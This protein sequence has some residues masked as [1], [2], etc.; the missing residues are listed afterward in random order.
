M[1]R[2]PKVKEVKPTY[3][4]TLRSPEAWNQ[5]QTHSDSGET[6]SEA[7]FSISGYRLDIFHMKTP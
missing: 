6:H 4:V 7:G 2:S 1:K 3:P 5:L